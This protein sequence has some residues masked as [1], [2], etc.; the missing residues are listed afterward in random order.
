MKLELIHFC[1]ATI[2]ASFVFLSNF[3]I[4][5]ITFTYSSSY[6]RFSSFFLLPI[7][8]SE[9]FSPA[10]CTILLKSCFIASIL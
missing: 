5:D 2:K 6:F 3:R 9:N 10:I 7:L 1:M 8:S 4:F